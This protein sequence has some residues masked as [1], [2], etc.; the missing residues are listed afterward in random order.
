VTIFVTRGPSAPTLRRISSTR[1]VTRGRSFLLPATQPR[2]A[3]PL[4]T[5]YER[6][7]ETAAQRQLVARRRLFAAGLLPDEVPYR[8]E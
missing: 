7:D 2:V 5:R 6:I 8:G 3:D 4:P 1:F